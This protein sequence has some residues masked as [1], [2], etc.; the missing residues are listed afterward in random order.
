LPSLS[1]PVGEKGGQTIHDHHSVL[2]SRPL[3]YLGHLCGRLDGRPLGGTGAPVLFDASSHLVVT[4]YPCGHV[5]HLP[6]TCGDLLGKFLSISALATARAAKNQNQLTHQKACSSDFPFRSYAV[7]R[8][9]RPSG[10][11]LDQEL[12]WLAAKPSLDTAFGLLNRRFG[13]QPCSSSS[14]RPFDLG[15]LYRGQYRL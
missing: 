4:S 8:L 5:S 7:R 1:Q 12:H 15:H 13:S 6:G 11:Y 10:P 2:F 3:D 14:A 9:S